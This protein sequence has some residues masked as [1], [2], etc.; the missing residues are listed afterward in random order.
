MKKLI[1]IFIVS[2]LF[3]GL[4]WAQSATII[5][6]SCSTATDGWIFNDGGGLAIQQTGTGG[7]WLIDHEEDYITTPSID[8]TGY[9]GLVLTFQVATYGS[10][11]N[12]PA[13]VQYSVDGGITWATE[14]FTSATPSTSNYISS[15]T[16]AIGT[17]DTDNFQLKWSRPTAT[18]KG[19]R[20]KNILL[21]ADPIGVSTPVLGVTP[22]TI[23]NLNYTHGEGPSVAQ[24]FFIVGTAIDDEVIVAAPTNF[25]ISLSETGYYF[26]TLSLAHV[27]NELD[28]V[29]VF[30]RLAPGL[31]V[32]SY[33][34]IITIDTDGAE[35]KTVTVS[36]SVFQPV[37]DNGY[38]V[39]FEDGEKT[40]YGSAPVTLNGIEWNMT[41]VLVGGG[42]SSEW[43]NGLKS[44]RLRGYGTSSM[45]MLEDKT[46]G[47]GTVSF[48]YRR[49]G[50]DAQ[51]DWKVEYSI[52]QGAN[53]TQI[54]S[55][56][57]PPA[58]NDVQEF[59]EA[60]NVDGDV[61]I[62][63]KRETESGS[64]NRRFNIDDIFL[65]DYSG[66]TPV[67][68]TPVFS[69][70]GGHYT[71]AQTVSITSATEDAT[72]R[73]TI[74]GSTPSAVDGE[75]YVSP[76][77]IDA[78]TTLKAIAYKVGYLNS[79]VKTAEYTFPAP[80]TMV[81]NIAALRA[82]ATDGTVYHLTGEA[83]LTYQ[84]DSRHTK[85]IQDDTA[86]I[87]IDDYSGIITTEYDLYDGIT[88]IMGTL[89]LYSG[90]LQFVPT[91]NP[92]AA[93][94][95][96]NV[97]VPELKTLDQLT[98]AD[99]AKLVK[100]EGLQ[101][102]NPDGNFV[103]TP[104]QNLDATDGTNT[105]VIRT[106]VNTDY[107]N[108]AIPTEPFDLVALVG[109]FNAGMQLSPRF[110]ADFTE[111]VPAFDFG[112]DDPQ[113]IDAETIAEI[114]GAGFLG[115]NI[116]IVPP[117]SLTPFPNADFTPTA[118][119]K[120][121]LFG[122]GDV[123]I[124]VYTEND[125]FA[126]VAGGVWNTVEG[127]TVHDIPFN[128]GAKDAAFEFMTGN[129][130]NPTLPVELS[131]FN[132]I[133]MVENGNVMLSWKTESETQMQGY[134]IYRS[135]DRE[136][137]NALM[138][139]PVMIEATNNST[140]AKYSYVDNELS[141]GTYYYWL[142][143]VGY[144]SSEYYGYQSV[145]VENPAAPQL[146]SIS[147]MSNAYPNPFKTST[148]VD[149]DVKA[150]EKANFTVYN[151]LGQAVYSKTLNEGQTIVEWNG[152][153][154]NGKRCGSGIYFYKLSSPSTSQTKKMVIVK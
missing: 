140:G 108:T 47:L 54:G 40:S 126:W 49:Y 45:T 141:E 73:Y 146:P 64:A 131:Y 95:S 25:Q 139:T 132:A 29:E 46:N 63:I 77:V 71:E 43:K 16:W 110:L 115:G 23:S 36:G 10:G 3:V 124:S 61:R 33:S 38:F 85:Y 113:I 82:G 21:K 72:I 112:A 128:L 86:A 119:G 20:M 93:T 56:F 90:L 116:V 60:V 53:W 66:G 52:D 87:V 125:W 106:F 7:Y 67:A 50:T 31:D 79:A 11:T 58:S 103:A 117:E 12:S 22:E 111:P 39:D 149:I 91:A 134:R 28:N 44:A 153:D 135:E 127:G 8:V 62:R 145:V 136:L 35:G 133:Y 55:V 138:I 14:T 5:D 100:V 122:T 130:T 51:V 34:G 142:E 114:T 101:F 144:N 148:K 18:G 81:A 78:N 98:S 109:Q 6:N 154:K 143:A 70:D 75:I 121:M 97:I 129:G 30:V 13:T 57:T 1:S 68:A 123:T 92:G 89:N 99:Q 96:D 15:G 118:R 104:A 150:G 94:S 147:S 48:F 65:S 137:A 9:Q 19:V 4:A 41:D 42:E 84:N 88:G 27:D 83:V 80:P 17:F 37:P 32:N 120:W 24:S 105:I 2:L 152:L 26:S 102:V 76:I 59:N 74:D 69:P 107:A 151:M